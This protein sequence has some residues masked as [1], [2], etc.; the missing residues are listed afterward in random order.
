VPLPPELIAAYQKALYV[1]F[2]EPELVLRIGEPSPGL[3]ALLAARAAS[4]A[5]FVT[6]ANPRGQRWT[7]A[8]NQAAVAGLLK[9][10]L[11]EGCAW[12]AGEGRDAEGRWPAEPSVLLLG[13]SR[14][15][16]QEIGRVYGQNSIVFAELGKAPELVLLAA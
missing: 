3:D 1:V 12:L 2:G 8:A 6:A 14:A 11:L 13:V 10:R 7:D 4:A 5:A 15:K 16:A 9:S